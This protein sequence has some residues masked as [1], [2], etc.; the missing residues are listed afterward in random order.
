MKLA[1]DYIQESMV[2]V[3]LSNVFYDDQSIPSVA[4]DYETAT[5]DI[6]KR[7]LAYG[8]K[9]VYLFSTVRRYSIN[10]KKEAGY[11]DAMKEAGLEP[12]IF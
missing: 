4:I 1:M 10:A 3:V 2:P 6:T 8:R 7:M 11:I 9:N 5:Y 12:R